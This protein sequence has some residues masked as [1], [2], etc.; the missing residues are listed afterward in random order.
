LERSGLLVY[1]V[2]YIADDTKETIMELDRL[3]AKVRDFR[4]TSPQHIK[5]LEKRLQNRAKSEG[6][7]VVNLANSELRG[8]TA[9]AEKHFVTI[10]GI[11]KAIEVAD[12]VPK[13][14]NF[15]ALVQG[16]LKKDWLRNKYLDSV[17]YNLSQ[18]SMESAVNNNFDDFNEAEIMQ[19]Q[20]K[21]PPKQVK[22]SSKSTKIKSAKAKSKKSTKKAKVSKRQRVEGLVS[23]GVMKEIKQL[24]G[25]RGE[26]Q[27]ET[28]A[29]LITKGLAVEAL[30]AVK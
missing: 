7:N 13:P 16:I 2:W 15:A 27:C 10:G 17:A 19:I 3:N 22:T 1:K 11:R 5:I 4:V 28:V 29:V 8:Y 24:A 20:E 23:A 14:E 21:F 6:E 30:R 9:W 26:K 18:E 12:K 25:S